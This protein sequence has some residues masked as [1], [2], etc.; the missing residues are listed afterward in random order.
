MKKIIQIML[1]LVL[2]LTLPYTGAAD[3]YPEAGAVSKTNARYVPRISYPT[4]LVGDAKQPETVKLLLNH[5]SSEEAGQ[6]F[7]RFG[8]ILRE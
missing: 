8:F 7:K 5:L 6:V 2:L 1:W 3:I 4:A